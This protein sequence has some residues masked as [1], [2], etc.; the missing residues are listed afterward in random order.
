M[1][2]QGRQSLAAV[3]AGPLIVYKCSM[4][5]LLLFVLGFAVLCGVLSY[6]VDHLNNIVKLGQFSVYGRFVLG[7]RMTCTVD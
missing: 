2:Y 3:V 4:R 1:Y 5:H 6:L 7:R